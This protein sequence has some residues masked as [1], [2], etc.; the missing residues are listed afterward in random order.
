VDHD[1]FSLTAQNRRF[2]I[3]QVG[4][5]AQG[6]IKRSGRGGLWQQVIHPLSNEAKTRRFLFFIALTKE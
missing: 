4:T 1:E 2:I 5:L 6:V 3:Y